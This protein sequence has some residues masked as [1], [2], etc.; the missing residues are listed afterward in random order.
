MDKADKRGPI[1]T[2]P[3]L[4]EIHHSGQ[5]RWVGQLHRL[6][7]MDRHP[8]AVKVDL[9]AAMVEGP[10]CMALTPMAVTMEAVL[11]PIGLLELDPAP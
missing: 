7:G 9:E 10:A 6:A 1:M 5:A 4:P 3:K 8:Q 2:G 11:L